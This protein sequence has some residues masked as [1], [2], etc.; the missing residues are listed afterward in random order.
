MNLIVFIGNFGNVLVVLWVCVFGLFIGC[1]CLV[2]NV[3]VILLEFFGGVDYCFC[4][5]V[6]IIVNVM[7]VGVFSNVECLCWLFDDVMLC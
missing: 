6:V 7:D 2:C 4:E 5:V 1:V 3:N